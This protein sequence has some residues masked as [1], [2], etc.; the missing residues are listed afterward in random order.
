MAGAS[1]TDAR[2]LSSR[3]IVIVAALAVLVLAGVGTTVYFLTRGDEPAA[4]QGGQSGGPAATAPTN[5][6]QSGSTP[7]SPP[8]PPT[9]AAAAEVGNARQVAEQAVKA[10]NAHDADG[11][12]KISCDSEGIGADTIPQEARV[13]LASNP[14]LT[15]DTGTVDLKL[16]LG[17]ASTTTPLP[18]RKENGAWCVG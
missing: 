2:K 15:G 12:K 14:E 1:P 16:I 3:T 5:A 13:E 18:L 11:M 4:N 17:E 8:P 10:F 7:A 9:G 6:G